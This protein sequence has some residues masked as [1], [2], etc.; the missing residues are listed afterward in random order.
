MYNH[1]MAGFIAFCVVV[2]AAGCIWSVFHEK[3]YPDELRGLGTPIVSSVYTDG[4]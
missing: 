4:E 1:I 3:V 2:L